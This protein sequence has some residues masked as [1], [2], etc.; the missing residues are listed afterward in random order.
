MKLWRGCSLAFCGWRPGRLQQPTARR[1]HRHPAPVTSNYPALMSVVPRLGNP[2]L[3]PESHLLGINPTGNK[4]K[5]RVRAVP[6]DHI[7]GAEGSLITQQLE[8]LGKSQGV[9]LV[10]LDRH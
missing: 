1:T 6:E 2:G 9:T 10:L 3:N 5:G 4:T 7:G 8:C